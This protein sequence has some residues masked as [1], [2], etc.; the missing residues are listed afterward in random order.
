MDFSRRSGLLV[1]NRCD[2]APPD[3]IPTLR[4]LYADRLD[5]LPVSAATGEGLDELR[6]RIWALLAVI[7]IYTKQPGKPAD[8]D[9]P[10]TL[11]AG[12][13]I[14]DL[15]RE[16]HRELPEKMRYA[17]VWGE[18]HFDGQQVRRDEPLGDKD[19]VE[20]HE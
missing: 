11:D 4:E 12:S 16:V 3:N 2:I 7:R 20:I 6:D 13:T 15:A 8:Y 14:A 1:A 10:F 5:I 18:H 17:R 19:V 9:K